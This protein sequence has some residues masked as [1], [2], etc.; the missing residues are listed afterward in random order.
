MTPPN[1][2]LL[3][4]YT[5]RLRRLRRQG[6]VYRW[7]LAEEM[8]LSLVSIDAARPVLDALFK[9]QDVLDPTN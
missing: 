5:D 6:P 8:R 3:R 2:E 4:E 9:G 1:D 7:D